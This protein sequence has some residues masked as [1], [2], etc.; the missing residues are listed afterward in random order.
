MPD[1]CM[2]GWFNGCP[3]MDETWA[4]SRSRRGFRLL[5]FDGPRPPVVSNWFQNAPVMRCDMVRC[6]ALRC[7]VAGTVISFGRHYQK[8]HDAT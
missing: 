6:G 3:G 1:E 2:D 8:P 5:R 4:A 7:G